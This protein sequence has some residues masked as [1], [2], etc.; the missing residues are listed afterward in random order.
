M[1]VQFISTKY[2]AIIDY[3]MGVSL[4]CIPFMFYNW[5]NSV[6]MQVLVVSGAF[7]L[8]YSL[9]TRYEYSLF[10]MISIRF[11]LTLDVFTGIMLIISPWMFNFFQ[12]VF[13]PHVTLGILQIAIVAFSSTTRAHQ[14]YT[15]PYHNKF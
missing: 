9:V 1:F 3:L 5:D 11:H 12:E 15:G 4:I 2:H 14:L 13:I 7:I 10:K 6:Q 8:F